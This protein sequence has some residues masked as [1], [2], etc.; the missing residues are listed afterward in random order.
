VYGNLRCLLS[1]TIDC[2]TTETQLEYLSKSVTKQKL[3]IGVEQNGRAEI[4]F[5][6][7][8]G[9]YIAG[10]RSVQRIQNLHAILQELTSTDIKWNYAYRIVTEVHTLQNAELFCSDGGEASLE[11]AYEPNGLPV[12][13]SGQLQTTRTNIEHYPRVTG[14]IAFGAVRYI[15]LL[16]QFIGALDVP[17][18]EFRDADPYVREE[19]EDE[20]NDE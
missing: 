15:R 5:G 16:S 12:V 9:L 11:V 10:R 1:T 3:A 13:A 17:D 7:A 19:Y 4:R 20:L 6:K 2:E 14:T 8:P 18:F